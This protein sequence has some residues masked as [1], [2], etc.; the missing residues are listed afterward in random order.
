V[1]Q[2]RVLPHAEADLE[3]NRLEALA[4]VTHHLLDD[5]AERIGITAPVGAGGVGADV[6]AKGSAHQ[7]MD[8]CLE[9]LALD[10]PQRNVDAAQRRDGEAPL[11]LIAELVVEVHP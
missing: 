5:V 11:A 7:H 8:R 9:A 4:H 3:F 2:R 10:V 1:N 6:A